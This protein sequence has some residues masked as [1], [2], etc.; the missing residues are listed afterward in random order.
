[1]LGPEV[2]LSCEGECGVFNH[3]P[4]LLALVRRFGGEPPCGYRSAIQSLTCTD[5]ASDDP[6][7]C[8][9]DQLPLVRFASEVLATLES[10]DW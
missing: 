2:A 5:C 4:R 1:M 6:R 7:Q 10:Q 3:L 8:V 9:C